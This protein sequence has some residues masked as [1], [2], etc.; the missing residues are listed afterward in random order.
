M[1]HNH[2]KGFL[3]LVVVMLILASAMFSQKQDPEK[4]LFFPKQVDLPNDKEGTIV[5]EFSFP[6]DRIEINGE[7]PDTILFLS[8]DTIPGLGISYSVDKGI[9]YG[10][11]PLMT[12]GRKDIIDN[13][14][15]HLTYSFDTNR[16]IQALFLDGELLIE[17]S[18]RGNVDLVT[19]MMVYKQKEYIESSIDLKISVK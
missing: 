13:N 7:M 10:G 16:G 18:Y 15:H 12:T 1:K 11:L 3:F 14:V 9:F 2:N 8:S 17:D 19:G 4:V 5:F 6:A